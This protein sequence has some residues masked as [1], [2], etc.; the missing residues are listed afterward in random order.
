VTARAAALFAIAAVVACAMRGSAPAR[1]IP[2]RVPVVVAPGTSHAV[3][4][5]AEIAATP[6]ERNRG[7]GGRAELPDDGGMLFVYATAEQRTYWMKDCLI[8]LDIAFIGDDRRIVNVATLPAAAGLPDSL[9]PK[10]GSRAPA[11]YVLET[12]AGWFARHGLGAGDE[13]DVSAGVAGV[14]PR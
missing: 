3:T 2:T 11:R 13:V 9:I 4:V 1:S 8:A 14:V 5:L 6:E 12:T 7:L 10:A